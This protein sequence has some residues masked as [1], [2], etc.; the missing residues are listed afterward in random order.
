MASAAGKQ[1]IGSRRM[2]AYAVVFTLA[3]LLVLELF[4]RWIEP[5][6]YR[7][8]R[9]FNVS[10]ALSEYKLWQQTL[11]MS[12]GGVH[13]PDPDLL[14]KFRPRL[15]Q[16]L[17]VTNSRGLLTADEIE[18]EKPPNTIRI[19]LL[20]DSSPVG[21]GLAGRVDAFGELAAR[22][23]EQMWRGQKRIELINAAVSGYT[24]EQGR[25]FLQT[26]GLKYHPDFVVCYFGN[27]DAS[28]NGY[29][30]DREVFAAQGW[31]REA[32][33]FFYRL[34]IYRMLRNV[35]SPVLPVRREAE[36]GL[37]TVRVTAEDFGEN[38]AAIADSARKAGAQVILMNPPIPDHWPA[39]LQ[40]KIF[41][42][43]TD[44]AGQWVVADPVQR[45]LERPLAYCIDSSVVNRAS[46]RTDPYTAAV[47]ASAY[48]DEGKADSI[49]AVYT[50]RLAENPLDA[51]SLNNL[52]V[53]YWRQRQYDRAAD[54][55]RR[56]LVADSSMNVGRY[57]LGITLGDAGD[58]AAASVLQEAVDR[59]YY[60][61]RIKSPYRRA[62][63][64]AADARG[65]P[66]VDGPGIFAGQGNEHLFIDHCHPT[67][68]G[69]FLLAERL[70]LVIDSLMRQ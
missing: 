15:R 47:F 55:F 48:A 54:L 3:G 22:L 66:V 1:R 60:S 68:E 23:L 64:G 42:H 7:N 41:A 36:N 2:A 52:G 14:W 33:A 4:A 70:A 24:S 12:F 63:S 39:G 57:N 61:L 40:F 34:A 10:E 28:I 25:R 26:E 37:P 45:Q 30:T 27:N 58:S 21:L 19:L 29:L 13:Q 16:P 32:R 11:F 38:L 43:L 6:A 20:G 5:A 56:C 49:E 50:R 62:L 44:S 46:G 9:K 53:M 35:L 31:A 18:F 69:H 65:L 67:P 51:V 59:D 8:L 17:F